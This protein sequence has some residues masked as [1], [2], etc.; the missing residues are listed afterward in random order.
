MSS[1]SHILTP[2]FKKS[3]AHHIATPGHKLFKTYSAAVLVLLFI[4]SVAPSNAYSD[5]SSSG[6]LQNYW[7]STSTDTALMTDQEG[8]L[9]KVNP[10]TSNGDRSTVNDYLTHTVAS[11]ETVSTI[12]AQYGLKTNTVLWANGL[13][14]ANSLKI[15]Q[16]LLIPPTDGIYHTVTK[17][18]SLTKIASTF[19]VKSDDIV[20]QNALVASTDIAIGDN[21]FIPGAKP[22][23]TDTPKV[24]GR[25][26]PARVAAGSRVASVA[27]SG[28]AILQGTSSVPAGDKPFIFPTR[29]QIT[30]GFHP[31]HYAYDIGNP[32][33]PA[34]WAAGEGVV[35]K[36]VS[37][38]SD[39]SA[40]CGGG[41]GN[42]VIIDHG[43]GLQTLYG[44][45]TYPSVAVGDHVDQG[46][47]IGKMG[48][49]GNVHGITGIHLHFEVR[50]NGV[51]Q[52]PGNYY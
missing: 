19:N 35:V 12:A 39:Y 42:H 25:D 11:G 29:G 2:Y 43:N 51:K 23:V 30:Q 22:L 32:D 8:Y 28:G 15:D 45:M 24:A 1:V 46:Q 36:V 26:T 3:Q 4:G 20:K 44:H 10:Q 13:A 52:S 21:I 37:G 9:T 48:R 34:I 5:S 16:Q 38:C 18:E 6:D 41:Y 14:N 47:V 7:D 50:K 33:R 17:G 27:V 49:S 40:R 31:G